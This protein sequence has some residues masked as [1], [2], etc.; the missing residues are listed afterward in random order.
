[1]HSEPPRGPGPDPTTWVLPVAN[2]TTPGSRVGTWTRCVTIDGS[3]EAV[4]D[5]CGLVSAV[6]SGPTIDWWVGAHDR[7]FFPSRE[8]TV[9]QSL[10]EDTPV[11]ETLMHIP[12]GDA[13]QR[14]YGIR[15]SSSEGGGEAL[16]IEVENA[17]SMPIAMAFAVR[18]FGI[19]G[20]APIHTVSI[21]GNRI[22]ADGTTVLVL[23]R[24]PNRAAA[25]IGSE[26]D[27]ATFV[28]DGNAGDSTFPPTTCPDGLAQ[29]VAIVPVPHRAT[30]RVVV[31]LPGPDGLLDDNASSF[32]SALPTSTQVVD[33]WHAQ[34]RGLA[35][36]TVPDSRMQS[37]F[38]AACALLLA[39]PTERLARGGA[40]L[41]DPDAPA[42]WDHVA[43]VARALGEIGLADRAGELL[44][45]AAYECGAE[46]RIGSRS[47]DYPG[48]AWLVVACGDHLSRH[49]DRD[50]AIALADTTELIVAGLGGGRRRLRRSQPVLVAIPGGVGAVARAAAVVF[51]QAGDMRGAADA[52]RVAEASGTQAVAPPTGIAADAVTRAIWA[53]DTVVSGSPGDA[54]RTLDTLLDAVSSTAAWPARF[55]TDLDAPPDG[56]NH[57]VATAAGVLSLALALL[58]HQD[59]DHLRLLPAVPTNWFGHPIEVQHVAT[60]LGMVS[61][62]VR[63]HE[64]RPALLWEVTSTA[65]TEAVGIEAPTLDDT[66]HTHER[67]GEALL[68][69]VEMLQPDKPAGVVVTGLQIGRPGTSR[70]I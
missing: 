4:V 51:T 42:R 35:H 39:A 64:N 65:A 9:R 44:A 22:I 11:V 10:V 45:R 53:T 23:P 1:M 21:E 17:S 56:D 68:G 20:P 66:W 27:L 48:L 63:W 28:V 41:R 16:V 6:E 2:D 57:S 12:G 8:A 62:V 50:L 61:Y 46:G 38:D 31:P 14:V 58:V 67:S 37:V 47:A 5:S 29:A 26:G 69:P 19:S 32:P 54:W 25:G 33:G 59:D 15:R 13:R 30:I 52:A 40:T 55:P 36:I 3:A 70:G 43:V 34:T 7:W 49:P 24:N 18:P 60:L